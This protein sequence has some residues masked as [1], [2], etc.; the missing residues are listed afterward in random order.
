MNGVLPIQC[1]WHHMHD[2]HRHGAH[3]Q[4]P[5]I[6][7]GAAPLS[8]GRVADIDVS[9]ECQGQCEPVASRV[10]YLGSGLQGKL[11]EEAG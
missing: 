3:D 8:Q 10:E 9:L 2:R 6:G 4:H 7:D 11:K 1:S 5:G